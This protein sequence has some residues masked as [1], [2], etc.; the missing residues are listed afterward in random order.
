MLHKRHSHPAARARLTHATRLTACGCGMGACKLRSVIMAQASLLSWGRMRSVSHISV[1][2]L[3]CLVCSFQR[4]TNLRVQVR[5]VPIVGVTCLTAARS[6]LLRSRLFDVCVLDEASQVTMPACLPP[7][8]RARTF[9]LVGDH[10]QLPPLVRSREAE[11]RWPD[12]S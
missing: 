12:P 11:V 2:A 10:Y 8:L 5:S 4:S 1:G 9:V 3:A 6:P 7:L